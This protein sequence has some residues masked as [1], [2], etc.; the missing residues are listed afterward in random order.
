MN[1]WVTQD[2][3][4]INGSLT[5]DIS[6]EVGGSILRVSVRYVD[7]GFVMTDGGTE[8]FV[9]GALRDDGELSIVISDAQAHAAV[10][11]A[12]STYHLF[13][14]GEAW[15]F[16]LI[17]PLGSRGKQDAQEGSL[18]SPMPGL[19]TMLLVEPGAHVA[20]G[21]PLL[22]LEAMKMEYTIKAPA[23][24]TVESF[25]N[26]AGDRVSEGVQLVHFRRAKEDSE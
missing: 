26:A 13:L 3:F 20:A 7:G 18:L 2:G 23:A 15:A 24:G 4:R 16:T 6:F 19:L 25:T 8:A 17:D 9:K 21:T 5:R 14:R 10:V 1:P 12:G 11:E 22:V